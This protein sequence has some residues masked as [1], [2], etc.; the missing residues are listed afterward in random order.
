[1]AETRSPARSRDA[2]RSRAAI[3]RAAEELF[4]RSGFDGATLQEIG[5]RAGLSRGAPAYFFTNKE[6][7]Y[8]AILDRLF[9]DRDAAV[10]EAFAAL[11]TY[12]EGDRTASLEESLRAAVAGYLRFLLERPAFVR[13]VQWEALDDGRQ[14]RA[15]EVRSR[16]AEQGFAALREARASAGHARFDHRQ[17]VVLFT[18]LCFM[19]V[20]YSTT[21]LSALELDLGSDEE[22][23]RHAALVVRSLIDLIGN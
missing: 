10:R 19:P 17:A 7:L 3:L 23:R 1:M 8:D 20:A 4:A 5:E 14:L 6:T 13:V 11:L 12:A 2:P 22:L 15:S 21:F 16:A 18:S 9:A